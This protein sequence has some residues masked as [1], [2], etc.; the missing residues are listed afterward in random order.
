MAPATTIP[1]KS[2]GHQR[3]KAAKSDGASK[4]QADLA[5]GDGDA[6]AGALQPVKEPQEEDEFED[7]GTEGE[8]ENK[9]AQSEESD[10][11][12]IDIQLEQ[13]E[14]KKEKPVLPKDAEEEELERI[15]FGDSE[16]FR[17]GLE[18]FSLDRTTGA[19][20]DDS[21]ES[22]A[23]EASLDGVADQDLFFFDAGPVAAPAGSVAPKGTE[24]SD[25]EDEKPAW[26]DSDD[27]RLVVSLA[28]VPQL[29]KLRE[30]ADDDVVNGKEYS[31]RLRKQYERLYP[32][33]NWAAYATGKANKKRRRT[34]EEDESGNESASDMDVDDED[35]S[36]AP[37]AKLLKDADILSRVSRGSAKRRKLQAGTIDI[38]RLKDVSKA[39]PSAITSLSFHPTYP[40]L[41]SSGPSSTLYLHH[42]NPNPPNP[43]PLLTSLH[44][45]RTP[46]VT[47]AFH[48][49]ASDSRIF[50]SARRRYFHVWNIATG[51]VEKVSR[52]YGHQHEQRTMEFFA[53]SPNG[54][55]MALRGSSRKGGGVINILDARTLQ[56][57]TQVR[58]ESRGGIADFAW[59]GDG[60]GMCIAGKNGE[61]TEWSVEDGIVGRWNDEGAVG[62]T[63]I[64]L[65][66]KSGR[67]NWLGGDRWVA[68]GSSSGVVNIYDRRAWSENDP[69]LSTAE[70]DANGGIPPAPKP[71]RDLQNLTTPISHLAFTPDGQ[72]LAMASRWKNNAMRLVHLPSATVFKNW[73]SQKTPLGRITAV[74]WGR[75]SEDEEKEGSLA[76]LAVANEAGHI[77]MWEIR[78]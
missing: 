28:S 64:A 31:R 24:E 39:G 4:H 57:T 77:R 49:S 14:K 11:E 34:M 47:T 12:S 10:E 32:T 60:T 15:I 75:P 3:Y 52:V 2:G 20:G 72:V 50:L 73:P 59:W 22:G 23:E 41:L 25:D 54:K 21:D 48:P 1:H 17:Q 65:G 43:N 76:Q 69:S 42:V 18:N 46:L 35:L 67:E 71:L 36:T 62:T 37:L 38:Q 13:K 29:R 63:V 9:G 61:V 45:K 16:G 7:F 53:L 19:Y 70:A 55:Y 51:R 6:E 40:L 30:T 5:A 8:D 58:I 68:I 44:V 26:E 78:A 74:A 66:G 27:E 56:W 33:P